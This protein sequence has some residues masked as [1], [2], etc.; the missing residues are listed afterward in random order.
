MTLM[1]SFTVWVEIQELGRD[2]L[3]GQPARHER[4]HLGLAVGEPIGL[5]QDWHD[6]GRA[7][8]LE[9]HCD[10]PVGSKRGSVKLQ[11]AA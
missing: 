9:H 1:W 6:V 2:L 3:G 11:P 5:Q 7:G 4:H 10:P 8:R